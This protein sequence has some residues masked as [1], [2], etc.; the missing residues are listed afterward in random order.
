MDGNGADSPFN[1]QMNASSAVK[2]KD[3]CDHFMRHLQEVNLNFQKDR[4]KE[5]LRKDWN[6]HCK[7]LVRFENM[8]L[9]EPEGKQQK[10]CIKKKPTCT[11]NNILFWTGVIVCLGHFG[12]R[13]T[14]CASRLGL[15]VVL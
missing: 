6:M 11:T 15:A 8:L 13:A 3:F 12:P 4:L 9:Q 10:L 1:F 14:L 5:Q 7:Y 2:D